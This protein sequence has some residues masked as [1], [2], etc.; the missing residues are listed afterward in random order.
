MDTKGNIC[1]SIIV[2]SLIMMAVSVLVGVLPLQAHGALEVACVPWKGNENL[3]HPTWDGK[4]ITLKGTVRYEGSVTYTWNF[5]DGAPGVSGTATTTAEYPCP[6]SIKHTYT[7][8]DGVEYVATLTVT[9]GA[10]TKSDTYLMQIKPMTL[11]VEADVAID[12]GLWR[13]YQDQVREARQGEAC[14]YWEPETP[15][16]RVGYTGTA[17]Q[18]FENNLHK[19]FGDPAK[20]PYVDCVRRGLNYLLSMARPVEIPPEDPY[21]GDT[22]GNGIGIACCDWETGGGDEMYEIGIAMMAIVSSDTPGRRAVTGPDGV[23]GRTYQEILQDMADYCAWAQNDAN[24]VDPDIQGIYLYDLSTSTQRHIST[25]SKVSPDVSGDKIVWED[26]L[27]E[28]VYVYDLTTNTETLLNS[29]GEEPAISGNKIVWE[30]ER[31]D[32]N[33]IYMYDLDTGTETAICTNPADQEEPAIS[34][35][36]IVWEDERNNN[37]DIY[38]YDLDTG[39]ETPICTNPAEQEGPAISGDKIVWMDFRNGNW[40]VY[41][42]DLD[43]ST[44]RQISTDSAHQALPAISGNKIVWLDTRNGNWDIYMYDLDTGTEMPICTAPGDQGF[45]AIS[46]NKIVWMDHRNGNWDIYMY[47]LGTG[48]ETPICTDPADQEDPAISGDKIVWSLYEGDPNRVGGWRYE[49]NDKDSDNSVTQW[50]IMGMV[51]A[52]TKWGITLADFVRPRLLDWLNYSQCTEDWAFGGFGYMWPCDWVNIAKTAGTGATGLVFCGVPGDDA[53]IQNAIGF[54]DRMWNLEDEE[55]WG[56]YYAMYGVMKAFS[57]EYLNRESIGAH[58]WWNEYARY[59]VDRQH[60]NGSW[61]PGQWSSHALSNAWAILI[62]TRALYDIPP[63]A[64][65]KANGLD[66]TEVDIGQEVQFDGSQSSNGTYQIVLYEWDWE[67]DGTYDYASPSPQAEHAYSEHA[68]DP[69]VVTLRVTDNR[70]VLTGGEKPP[71]TDTDTCTVSIHPPPHPPIADANGPY[72]GWVGQPVTLD[73]SASRDPNEVYD[74]HIVEWAWD[75]DND[76]EFD[77]AFG[78][79]VEHTWVTPGIYPIALRVKANE[80]PYLSEPSRTRVEIGNHDPVADPN[81]PYET[82]ACT[83]VTLNGSGSYDPDPAPD[84]IVSWEWDLDNDGEYDDAS[85]EFVEFHREAE[86]VYTVRLKVTDTYGA[87]GTAWTTVTVSG[88]LPKVEVEIDIKPGSCPNPLNVK[89]KGVLPVAVL[90]TMDFDVTTIDPGTIRL[91]RE[92]VDCFVQPIRWSCEDVATPFEGELCDCHD[93]NGDGYMDLTLKFD[94]QELVSCLALEEVAGETIPLKLT[95]NLK[96][97]AG[98]TPITGEDCVRVLNPGGK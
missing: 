52:E 80:E 76:G 10:E 26:D 21:G 48:T 58:N 45:P 25:G 57:E 5:G 78:Q 15:S 55:H 54:I 16:Y 84:Y 97:E 43:T 33:D 28:G 3:P 39:T 20:D 19:P 4:E 6:I 1:R 59:L 37:N 49:P 83:P 96:E 65:A 22:N 34:G 46:G 71:M 62:L 88:L 35:N 82:T 77:D 29:F 23:I 24:T 61:P 8:G 41:M 30:D 98:G 53:R 51:P 60:G 31:N 40:D 64:V 69:I 67:S 89:D 68:A 90:G 38:M 73:G 50:P 63:N 42:Y 56:N 85:G 47:D 9:A 81:G 11:D 86:G 7:G 79:I 92:P 44:E 13:L 93:L 27:Y 75:L 12:E 17:V 32:N 18:S 87:T 14:G 74:D 2:I 91:T 94:T 36:K 72:I 66:A 95:G 70:D